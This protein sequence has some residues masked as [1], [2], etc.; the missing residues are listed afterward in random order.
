MHHNGKVILNRDM[1]EYF[2]VKSTIEK[3]NKNIVT[4]GFNNESDSIIERFEEYKDYTHV[5]ASILGEPV[6]FNTFL[7]GKAMIEN[8]IGVL[9]IIKLLDIPLESIMYNLENY[10]PNNGVQNF[11][12]YKKK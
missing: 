3:Y 2:T 7:S 10:Q 4:Y 11:E 9:T 5:E 12:H 1:N 8:I 6:S